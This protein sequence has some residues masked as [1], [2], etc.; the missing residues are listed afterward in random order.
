MLGCYPLK[1]VKREPISQTRDVNELVFRTKISSKVKVGLPLG[2]YKAQF[3]I[4][5]ASTA[6]RQSVSMSV[7]SQHLRKNRPLSDYLDA[8]LLNCNR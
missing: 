7:H 3:L 6:Q 2:S 5:S 4:T 1:S 8:G